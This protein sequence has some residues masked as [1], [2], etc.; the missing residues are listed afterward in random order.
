MLFVTLSRLCLCPGPPHCGL[1]QWA[2]KQGFVCVCKLDLMGKGK[3]MSPEL[4]ATS[5]ST[6]WQHKA[7]LQPVFSIATGWMWPNKRETKRDFHPIPADKKVLFQLHISFLFEKC[8][9]LDSLK[10]NTNL[11]F[12][13]PSL[14][15]LCIWGPFSAPVYKDEPERQKESWRLMKSSL[16]GF[17]QH[18]CVNRELW[19]MMPC[20]CDLAENQSKDFCY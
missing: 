9:N 17:R 8:E 14:F 19:S 2:M 4:T 10:R 12:L 6:S 13:S 3:E 18:V 20:W 11:F 15:L 5:S 7:A 16:W 1:P